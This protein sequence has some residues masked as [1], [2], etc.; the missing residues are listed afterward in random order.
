MNVI[1]DDKVD[2]L[3]LEILKILSID[4]RKN[5]STIAEDLKRSPNTIIKHVKDLEEAGIIKNYGIQID[6]E[7]LGYNIIA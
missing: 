3:D 6:Y 4:S 2:E 5:K 7:K 1:K